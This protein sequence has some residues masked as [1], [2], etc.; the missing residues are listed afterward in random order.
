MPFSSDS[1]LAATGG[2]RKQ[3]SNLVTTGI[4]Y[5]RRG[6]PRRKEGS[7]SCLCTASSSETQNT[8]EQQLKCCSSQC[9]ATYTNRS[10]LIPNK[11]KPAISAINVIWLNLTSE[12]FRG[13]N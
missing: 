7:R 4:V 11:F 13:K 12:K 6:K 3:G 5:F 8:W 2:K 9:E 10:Q 1:V